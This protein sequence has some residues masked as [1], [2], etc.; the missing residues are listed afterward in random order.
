MTSLSPLLSILVL[1]AAAWLTGCSG[2]ESHCKSCF[3]QH[4]ANADGTGLRPLTT[5][6]SGATSDFPRS[7]TE[8]GWASS[9]S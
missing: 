6:R 3:Q 7:R 2:G 5:A 8:D 4:L 9:Y 1:T